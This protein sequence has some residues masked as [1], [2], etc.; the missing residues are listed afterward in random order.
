MSGLSTLWDEHVRAINDKG[1]GIE[2]EGEIRL[3]QLKNPAVE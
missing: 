1:L 3:V 2:K